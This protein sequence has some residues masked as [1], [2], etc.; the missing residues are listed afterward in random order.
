MM[1]DIFLPLI[2]FYALYQG[3]RVITD[4]ILKRMLIKRNHYD[5]AEI[6]SQGLALP[7]NAETS[8]TEPNKYPSLKWGLVAFMAGAGF[9]LID[10]L[11]I[12][13]PH[14]DEYNSALP[15]GIE[16]MFISAGFLLYFFIATFK[17]RD[18]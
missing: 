2:V 3:I 11:K 9:V 10:I 18:S 15:I 17:K 1:Q 13:M 12:Q 5:R 4:F 6:L 8:A 7:A 14:M 16:L